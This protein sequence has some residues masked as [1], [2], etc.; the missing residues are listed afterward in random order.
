MGMWRGGQNRY[1]PMIT[2]VAMGVSGN[3]VVMIME[4]PPRG[5]VTP[6]PKAVPTVTCLS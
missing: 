6:G 5:D 4:I 2:T 3:A 1:I